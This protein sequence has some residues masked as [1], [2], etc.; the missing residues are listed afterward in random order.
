MTLT[1]SLELEW[2]VGMITSPRLSTET[3]DGGGVRKVRKR[4]ETGAGGHRTCCSYSQCRPHPWLNLTTQ[5]QFPAEMLGVGPPE[6]I[7][8]QGEWETGVGT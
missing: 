2:G 8:E 7:L 5:G 3:G 6:V 4:V 1:S